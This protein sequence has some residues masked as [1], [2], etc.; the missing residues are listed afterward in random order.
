MNFVAGM[1]IVA[2][3][4]IDPRAL[5]CSDV[6]T[7]RS[8]DPWMSART[9]NFG[10]TRS[11]PP[12]FEMCDRSHNFDPLEILFRNE[13]STAVG[14]VVDTV[15]AACIRKPNRSAVTNVS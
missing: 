5:S 13:M 4:N 10:M 2:G 3:N 11:C 15:K 14:R 7:S 6:N 12:E 9:D 8:P 1:K